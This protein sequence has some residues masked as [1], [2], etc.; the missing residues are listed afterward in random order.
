MCVVGAVCGWGWNWHPGNKG[1]TCRTEGR[2]CRVWWG[3]S[4]GW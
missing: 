3:H 1:S 2:T 4:M